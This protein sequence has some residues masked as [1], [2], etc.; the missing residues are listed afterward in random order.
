MRTLTYD[1]FEMLLIE[2][3]KEAAARERAMAG[4]SDDSARRE[5]NR[6]AADLN[7]LA[8]SIE[9]DEDKLRLSPLYA[10]YE[11]GWEGPPSGEGLFG[12]HA[13]ETI[14]QFVF[15]DEASEERLIARLMEDAYADLR[16]D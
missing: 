16:S 15:E 7:A 3:I 5:H 9:R 13:R 4:D 6:R 12:A 2:A 14:S 1:Q 11:A 8:S 10:V